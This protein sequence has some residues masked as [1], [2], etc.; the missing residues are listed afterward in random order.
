M[1]FVE[2]VP[3]LTVLVIASLGLASVA[4]SLL[5]WRR[6]GLL[7][8][9]GQAGVSRYHRIG[10]PLAV[11]G[12]LLIL[13]SLC[14]RAFLPRLGEVFMR[15]AV[16]VRA[17]SSRGTPVISSAA[18]HASGE[19]I[20]SFV[21]S[22][23]QA[24]IE[25]L[26]LKRERIDNDAARLAEAPFETA[27]AVVR[28]ELEI[29]TERRAL[30]QR[31]SMLEIE[32]RR[33][34]QVL[35]SDL[36]D[37]KIRRHDVK[38]QLGEYD[39]K[40]QRM[41]AL[42]NYDTILVEQSR[43]LH[44]SEFISGASLAKQQRDTQ[45]SAAER[46]RLQ[47]E[48]KEKQALLEALDRGIASLE[49][50]L[51]EHDAHVELTTKRLDDESATLEVDQQLWDTQSDNERLRCERDRQ[52]EHR[53][54]MIRRQECDSGLEGIARRSSVVAP[55]SG[56]V[57]YRHEAPGA[58][59]TGEPIALFGAEGFV[60]ARFRLSESEAAALQEASVVPL[61][62]TA[63]NLLD[64]RITGTV[65]RFSPLTH[66]PGMVLVELSC[67]ATQTQARELAT[68]GALTA[69]LLWAPTIFSD[70][71]FL[72]GFAALSCGLFMFLR[73]SNHQRAGGALE[74]TVTSAKPAAG[75][76][77]APSSKETAQASPDA[78]LA[79]THRRAC[80]R[81]GDR[82]RV[83]DRRS[84]GCRRRDTIRVTVERRKGG[85]RR[86]TERRSKGER[87]MRP[88]R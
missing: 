63:D 83:V 71:F 31:R 57:L 34:T 67:A 30:A 24:E 10:L 55:F 26:R 81:V 3:F 46:Q 12:A 74:W 13:V 11:C 69:R 68:T 72:L 88:G 79:Q 60:R 5:V 54:L 48:R 58:A 73:P 49:T 16:V 39:G 4:L 82:R 86:V 21:R 53:D 35:Q 75:G 9:G 38:A 52:S 41:S 22:G 33:L 37:R 27:A 51:V 20:V 17:D 76:E 15:D 6:R 56:T 85:C 23:Q 70:W 64:P 28:R 25:A 19:E 40:L 61:L 87:R 42:L 66:E 78:G 44:E 77:S 45:V 80:R 65:V 59:K 43:E 8:R 18:Q 32:H 2:I 50:W 1:P 36:L 84:R 47:I 7:A 29:A 62:V 14:L